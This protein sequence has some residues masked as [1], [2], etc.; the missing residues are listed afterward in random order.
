M[1][2]LLPE[3]IRQRRTKAEF[4][5]VFAEAMNAQGGEQSFDSLAIASKWVEGEQVRNAYRE[6]AQL[7]TK[8]DQRYMRHIWMM[9]LIYGIELWFN[10]VFLNR[11]ALSPLRDAPVKNQ[12]PL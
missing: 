3:T 12:N 10:M 4:S 2:G 5:H 6:M 7:Y 1:H 8:G 9:W 11:E